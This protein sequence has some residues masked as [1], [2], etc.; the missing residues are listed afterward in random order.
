MKRTV[1]ELLNQQNS[2][3][4]ISLSERASVREAL[5]ILKEYS[6]G[7]ILITNQDQLMGTFSESDY[8]QWSLHHPDK[9]ILDFQLSSFQ[10]NR[11][12]YV[13]LDYTLEECFVVMSSLKTNHI[14]VVHNERPVAILNYADIL[15]VIVDDRQFMINELTKYITGQAMIN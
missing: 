11:I 9:H 12:P 10:L 4:P 2:K 13:N 5:I 14:T 1:R 8:V 6:H 7:I 15:K 3:S